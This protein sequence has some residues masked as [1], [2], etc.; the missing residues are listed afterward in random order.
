MYEKIA[1]HYLRKIIKSDGYF[2]TK[3]V[4]DAELLYPDFKERLRKAFTKWYEI[5]P[6]NNPYIVETYRSNKLQEVYFNNGASKI[7]KNGMHHYGIAADLAFMFDGKVTY[8][9]DY[10]L[11]RQLFKEEGLHLLGTWD[12]GHVQY[13]PATAKDQ[14]A[15]RQ[16]VDKAV[17][18]FQSECSL[19]VDGI[20]GP[21]TIAKAKEVFI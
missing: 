11:L 8:Q 14:N 6:S 2:S 17:R 5:Y 13:I 15:L 20:V 7:R 21:K 18:E 19:V 1:E 12:I 16:A 9:G 10:E 4:R 3:S